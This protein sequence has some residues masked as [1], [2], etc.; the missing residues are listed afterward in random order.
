MYHIPK[1]ASHLV[2]NPWPVAVRRILFMIAFLCMVAFMRSFLEWLFD[3]T[4]GTGRF[5]FNALSLAYLVAFTA[6]VVYLIM[7]RVGQESEDSGAGQ[8]RMF[9]FNAFLAIIAMYAIWDQQ[10][11][12]PLF[13]ETAP[14]AYPYPYRG[15]ILLVTTWL[16]MVLTLQ[17]V[18]TVIIALKDARGNVYDRDDEPI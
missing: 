13:V 8:V 7:R 17:M 12:T 10:N 4:T 14:E 18:G 16:G 2:V 6:I 1:R 5:E 15:S 3:H 11:F 9:S